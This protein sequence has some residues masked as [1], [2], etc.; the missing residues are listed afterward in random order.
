MTVPHSS[1]DYQP[2]PEGASE[3]EEG[4]RKELYETRETIRDLYEFPEELEK[5]VEKLSEQHLKEY[6][7]KI[8]QWYNSI[9]GNFA[10]EA[11]LCLE[12]YRECSR[13]HLKWRLLLA[14]V[15]GVLAVLNIV[16]AFT[17][18][19]DHLLVTL[20]PLFAAIWA[21]MIAVLANIESIFGHSGRAQKFREI[22]EMYLDAY[23]DAEIRWHVQVLPHGYSPKGCLNAAMALKGLYFV[24]V[25]T[26]RIAMNIDL[27]IGKKKGNKS[28]E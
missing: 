11:K 4:R 9:V 27:R 17:S 19:F 16:I 2:V 10:K 13:R 15:A 25:K 3:Q 18:K 23:R 5:A 8:D 6:Y 22:R 26:R 20:L 14:I 21:I 28:S 7:D 24:D 1:D 12:K